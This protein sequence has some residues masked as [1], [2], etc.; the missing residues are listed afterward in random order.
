MTCT[1]DTTSMGRLMAMPPVTGS[2]TLAL[3]TSAPL[4]VL[5]VPLRL[6]WPSGPHNSG[7]KRKGTLKPFIHVWS[8]TQRLV[9]NSFR[10]CGVF[11]LGSSCSYC[12]R[13]LHIGRLQLQLCSNNLAGLDA[14]RACGLEA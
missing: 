5:R 9:G 7:N 13:T 3:F 1:D 6:M 10:R 4:C 12:D 2:V 11:R 8:I 14:Y